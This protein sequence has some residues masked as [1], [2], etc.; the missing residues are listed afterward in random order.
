VQDTVAKIDRSRVADG[1][2]CVRS[3][4]EKQ[5]HKR[6]DAR[7]WAPRARFKDKVLW[8]EKSCLTEGGPPGYA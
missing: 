4:Y 1:C 6:S 7:I 2:G 8:W 3:G 5:N